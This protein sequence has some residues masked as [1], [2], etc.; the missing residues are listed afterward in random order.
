M[1]SINIIGR[2]GSEP[3]LKITQSGTPVCRFS[4][5]V[6]RPHVKD[7][8][9]WLPVSVWRQSAEY[10][11]KYARKGSMVAVNGVLTT[12]KYETSK[13]EKRVAYEIVADN[14]SVLSGNDTSQTSQ[15]P[16]Q[17]TNE[18]N[19]NTYASEAMSPEFEDLSGDQDLPF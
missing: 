7:I 4:L 18:A 16:T 5:A 1:N 17:D 3:E 12:R 8:I 15:I 14:V 13:G 6:K 19:F 10:I 11:S 9:D 2:M